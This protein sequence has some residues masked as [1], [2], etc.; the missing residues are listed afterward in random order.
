[1]PNKQP[2]LASF[3]TRPLLISADS[4]DFF[5]AS[6]EFV[7]SHEHA[8]DMTADFGTTARMS[9]D[10]D[11]WTE[12]NWRASLRPYVVVNGVLQVPVQGTLLNR[13]PYQLGRWATGYDY[14]ERAVARGMTDPNVRAVA[15]VIDSPGG[16]VA[17]CFELVDKLVGMGAEKPI[18]SFAADHS[19]SAAYAIASVGDE[20]VVTR[21]GGTGSVGVVTA[22]FNFEKALDQMGVEVTFIHAGK[23]KVDGNS[24]QKLPDDVKARIQAR[25][26][27]IYGVFTSTVAQNRDMDEDDVRGTEA[28]TYDAEDS[29]K[30][31]FADRIGALDDEMIAF[32]EEVAEAEDEQMTTKTTKTAGASATDNDNPI[33]QAALDAAV[34]DAKAEGMA[35]GA[36]AEKER[37]NA[38]LGS[39]EGKA[40]PKAALSAALKTD[41]TV[42]QA[43]AFLADLPEEKAEAPKT[44]PKD[45]APKAGATPFDAAMNGGD[46]P[47]VGATAGDGEEEE[48][49]AASIVAD[50]QSFTGVGKKRA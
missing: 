15:L 5:K 34:T 39:D 6:V 50:F 48:N 27:K 35:A 1:M 46:N 33:T 17:G 31:G 2:L 49:P 16:E 13:F 30:I 20:I 43:T 36:T 9:T 32:T 37:M 26:D 4:A 12:D 38:I 29:I 14:I 3:S 41:M 44:T 11:F 18:R 24:Y 42:E 25:V 7:V 47:N 28:L 21:S 40:H 22:H 19:Y 23:H 45:E 10:D 8:A